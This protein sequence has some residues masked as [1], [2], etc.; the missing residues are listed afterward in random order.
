MNKSVSGRLFTEME[1]R[2]AVDAGVKA[3]NAAITALALV[4]GNDPQETRRA[5]GAPLNTM[6]FTIFEQLNMEVKDGE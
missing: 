3:G 6:T 2:Q 4:S 5:L 1:V